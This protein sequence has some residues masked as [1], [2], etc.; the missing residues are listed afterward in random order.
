MIL[1]K[2]FLLGKYN[3]LYLIRNYQ[4]SSVLEMML[5]DLMI[6]ERELVSYIDTKFEAMKLGFDSLMEVINSEEIQK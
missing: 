3:G 1:N 5:D 4:C 6:N 2:D